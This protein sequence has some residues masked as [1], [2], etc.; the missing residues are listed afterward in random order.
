MGAGVL[1][2]PPESAARSAAQ[3]GGA[4]TGANTRTNK[5][6]AAERKDLAK[7]TV[8]APP[9]RGTGNKALSHF[10]GDS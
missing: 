3:T 1:P 9:K 6:T 7:K 10:T 8:M 4:N 5:M 2:I